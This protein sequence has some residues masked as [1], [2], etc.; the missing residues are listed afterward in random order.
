M[1]TRNNFD[2]LRL[3]AA[4]AVLVSHEFV[5]FARAEPLTL[6]PMNLGRMAVLVFFSIS[7]Y[8]VASSWA[9]DPTLWR[10]AARRFLRIWPAYMVAVVGSA[11]W[12]ACT[13]PRPLAGTGAWIYVH[14]HLLFQMFDWDFFWTQRDPRLNASLWTIQIEVFCYIGLALVGVLARRW[15]AAFLAVVG[16]TAFCVWSFGMAVFDPS[17][18]AV[19]TASM[20]FG[21]FFGLGALLFGFPVLRGPKATAALLVLGVLAF[22]A[23]SRLAGVTLVVPVLTVFVGTRSW[24]VLNDAGRFGDFSYGIY[25]WAW[26]VQQ[27]VA[28]RLGLRWGFGGAMAVSLLVT[29]ALAVASWH[30]VEA[31]ALRAKPRSTTAWPRALKLTLR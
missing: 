16:G 25:L 8:L 21:G 27:V 26:P 20:M 6:G 9:A 12:I 3:L 11:L 30:L 2:G 18:A 15:W 13:D 1:H 29:L 31:W 23:G 22:V 7:G 5:M 19:S 28:T 17:W 14:K 4:L 24:P 10:F